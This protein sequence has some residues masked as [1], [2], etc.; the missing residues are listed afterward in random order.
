MPISR[1]AIIDCSS[2]LAEAYYGPKVRYINLPVVFVSEWTLNGVF[3]DW[4]VCELV[5]VFFE[6]AYKVDSCRLN[7]FGTIPPSVDRAEKLS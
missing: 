4:A 1:Y 7:P 5:P 2:S 6:S 3:T